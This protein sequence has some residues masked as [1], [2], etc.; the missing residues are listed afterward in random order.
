MLSALR[1]RGLLWPTLL[2]LVALAVLLA[3][4]TWQMQRKAWK[5]RLLTA[6]AE[7][8]HGPPLPLAEVVA[9]RTAG[10]DTEY[11]RVRVTGRFLHTGERHVY[12]VLASQAGYLVYTPLLTE[13]GAIVLVNRGFVPERLK[14]PA[15]RTEG[16]VAGAQSLTGLMRLPGEPSWATP[17][18]EHA[19]NV[20]FWPDLAGMS[21]ALRA[22][23]EIGPQTPILPFFVDAEVE[24]R[25]PGGWPRGGTTNLALP[26][27]HLE[28]SLTWYGLALTL[29]GVW[30]AFVTS[31][32]RS[33]EGGDPPQ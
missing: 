23:P 11:Q 12:T 24:P 4:G 16:Q 22:L 21:L 2:A 33:T 5:E 29:I 15:T 7:R 13:T 3:L 10:A 6:I 9:R 28:Y 20:Y 27:R 1:R 14:I 19:R 17:T 30:I 18:S 25:N 8:A 26:N 32:W 31:R